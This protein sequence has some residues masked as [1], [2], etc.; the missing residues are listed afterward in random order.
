M[1]IKASASQDEATSILDQICEFAKK[2]EL[3]TKVVAN[4]KVISDELISNIIKFAYD[5]G[6]DGTILIRLLCNHDTKEL[7]I[8]IMDEGKEFNPFEGERE[9]ISGNIDDIQEGGLGILIV[10]KLCNSYAY[11]RINNKNV[12]YLNMKI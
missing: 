10:K 8:T 1:E 11:D 3:S 7:T 5:D 6:E 2:N 4:L 9:K 12:V